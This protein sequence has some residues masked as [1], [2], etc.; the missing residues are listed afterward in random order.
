MNPRIQVIGKAKDLLLGLVVSN[1]GRA[2][3]KGNDNGDE[4]VGKHIEN[5]RKRKRV[6]Q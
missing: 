1:I 3:K 6:H 4:A 5:S 2:G